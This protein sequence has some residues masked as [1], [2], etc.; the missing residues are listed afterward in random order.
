VDGIEADQ[1]NQHEEAAGHG[2]ND[3][4]YGRSPSLFVS[5]D[6]HQEEHGDNL[7]FPEKIEQ[8]E[9]RGHE[10]AQNSGEGQKQK[11]IIAARFFLDL[12]P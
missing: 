5:P 10:N 12:M 2:E 7:D 1:S 9:I 11:E 8:K 6:A 3:E 4:F